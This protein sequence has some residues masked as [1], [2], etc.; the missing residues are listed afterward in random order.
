[1]TEL[2]TGSVA[3]SSSVTAWPQEP[4]KGLNYFSAADA[5]L[6]GQREEEIHEVV[7]LLSNFDTRV[8]LL[9]GGSGAGKS[10]FIR[11]GLCARLPRLP[12][13]NGRKFF[14]LKERRKKT[15]IDDPLLIRATDDPIARIFEALQKSAAVESSSLCAE[16]REAIRELLVKPIPQ[17]RLEAVPLILAA[18]KILTAP[19]QRDTFVLLI[20]Q[21]EEVITLPAPAG[22]NNVRQAFFE[23]MEQ[24][25]FRSLD[26]R[27]I[28]AL[29]TE[30]YGRFCSYFLIR[31]TNRLTPPTEFGAGLM[32]Y[33]LRPLG[34]SDLAAAIRYPTSEQPRDG[35]PSP[36]SIY[37]FWYKGN[38]PETIAA[39]LVHQSG[40]GST[41]PAMQ[42]VCK[43]LYERVVVRGQ[44]SEI[45]EED[46]QLF[47]R[48][49]GAI[50]SFIV[51]ALRGAAKSAGL[52]PLSD[53]D[54]DSWALVLSQVV[55]QAEGGT[56]QTLIASEQ[57]LLREAADN[58]IV[59]D[60][61]RAM[62]SRM[63][64]PQWRL[65]RLVG[66]EGGSP[67]YSLGHDSLGP[68]V[69]R[70][71][72]EAAVRVEAENR[73]LAQRAAADVQLAHEREKADRLV[74]EER[75]KNRM[76]LSTAVATLLGIMV[77]GFAYHSIWIRPI[78]DKIDS[79]ISYAAR[80]VSNDF[81]LRLLLLVA[82][83]RIPDENSFASWFVNVEGAKEAIREELVRS[84]I[85]GGT[86][87]AAAWSSDG[88]R[89]VRFVDDKLIV[90]DL[91]T[92]E[93]SKATEFP[94]DVGGGPKIPPS[95]G[96]MRSEESEQLVAF[97]TSSATLFAGI[98]GSNLVD[99]G[100]VPPAPQPGVFIPR[101]D[102]FG[103]RVRINFLHFNKNAIT[104]MDVLQ[105]SELRH[106][107]VQEP[108]A[109]LD[110]NPSKEQA[111]R[112][113]V[114][115]E[116]CDAYTF[117]GR[118]DDGDG[119][120]LWLGRLGHKKELAERFSR[121][122][123]KG[124][125]ALALGAI[126]ISRNC[127]SIVALTR[128]DESASLSLHIMPLNPDQTRSVSEKQSFSLRSLPPDAVNITIP[129]VP[130]SQP[131]LAAVPLD[132]NKGWRVGWHT[133]GGLS[134]VE[135]ERDKPSPGGLLTGRPLL[136][137]A[138]STYVFGSLSFSPDG[139]YALFSQQQTFSGS[140]E[141]RAF[142]LNLDARRDTLR[143]LTATEALAREACRIAMF[144]DGSNWVRIAERRLF[145]GVDP[146]PCSGY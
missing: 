131:A 114:M 29:R 127:G 81:R 112:Q 136:T 70:R 76:I 54:V 103:R 122:N 60:V 130:Q 57:D 19:P 128:D 18:L 69:L 30:Y 58:G 56:I 132:A 20:D 13:E 107:A 140:I 77:A 27:L 102:I 72:A 33:L 36:R 59:A 16:V 11:A 50:D 118:D 75:Y 32:D 2:C 79:L 146:Q 12:A 7:G 15:N 66:G 119:Y 78:Q 101:A 40:E 37:R 8:V 10:S 90:R 92:G 31:P 142:N 129:S 52:P 95:V 61:V 80:D 110:W 63:I 88:H 116:D 109:T 143:K 86:F 46:Y 68:S 99:T 9:H 53:R 6:F 49:E 108:L 64:D 84:P 100:F 97:R 26:L 1:M 123:T 87:D 22:P 144:A 117:L 35:L 44:R 85:F 51:R 65:L 133:A 23:F 28:V 106:E 113:P 24:T 134:I 73:Q 139:E 94:S 38:L 55:G 39:D 138:Q 93:D 120:N 141:L 5:P 47:G 89:I 96:F 98:P 115:A 71:S 124:A 104:Q 42:I 41:L 21:A 48:A 67:A 14:F 4:Y 17:D 91:S 111:V 125:R 3:S 105:L 25:C 34:T 82:A 83:L 74:K 43:Q 62:L 126:A 137:G 121:K 145:A 135:V 45:S